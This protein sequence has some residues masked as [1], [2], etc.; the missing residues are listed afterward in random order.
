MTTPAAVRAFA[1]LADGRPRFAA[2]LAASAGIDTRDLVGALEALDAAGVAPVSDEAGRI[3]LPADFDYLDAAAI[4]SEL[5]ADTARRTPVELLMTAA[6]SNDVLLEAPPPP[7][8]TMSV[9]LVEFQHGGRGRR[10]R[11]WTAPPG[12]TLSL[13]AAWRF[14]AA[15]TAL[16]ALSLAVGVA[17]A[18]ALAA[19]A[20]VTIGLKWPNDLVFDR[21]KLGGVLVEA[22]T[23]GNGTSV[24]AGIG[25]NVRVSPERLAELSDWPRGAV[26]L[27]TAAGAAVPSRNRI[28]AALIGELRAAFGVFED[29]G[30]SAF[31][32]EWRSAHV[33]TGLPAVLAD[34]SGETA[35]VVVDVAGDGALLFEQAGEVRRVLSGELSLRPLS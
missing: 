29:Q 7:P 9:C 19:S 8:G 35:G 30:F 14:S 11:R 23:D 10:G 28:A 34:G 24:V 32:D 2:E 21:R 6:S 25:I 18:R 5:D 13:S 27:A 33:L 12:G 16:S 1:C 31:I 4:R 22:R 17:A 26:D 3:S 15:P 20:G